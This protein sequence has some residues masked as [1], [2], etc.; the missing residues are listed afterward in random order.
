MPQGLRTVLYI[1][2]KEIAGQLPKAGALL[3]GGS[4]G[5]YV[6]QSPTVNT[7]SWVKLSGGLPA[8]PVT[9]LAYDAQDDLLIVATLG[10]GAWEFSNLRESIFGIPQ[11]VTIV[12]N[13]GTAIYQ[14]AVIPNVTLTA[15]PKELDVT[16][17]K[18]SSLDPTTLPL[19]LNPNSGILVVYAGDDGTFYDTSSGANA[20]DTL[21][22]S[23]TDD[24]VLTPGYV[25]FSQSNPDEVIFRFANDLRR[26]I[27]S[28]PCGP[29]IVC[30]RRPESRRSVAES[31]GHR[32]CRQP[33]N[34]RGT[35][36]GIELHLEPA[37]PGG[38]G[39][40]AADR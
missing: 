13:D 30:R 26:Q 23:D 27:R 7:A 5:V 34:R 21:N 15:T 2:G 16:F 8:A 19:P 22:T 38:C 20:T 12:S 1:S 28:H 36:P 33:A 6:T 11:V 39:G 40:P 10:R 18:N 32:F 35:E 3:V 25:G 14:G 17:N 4:Q 31:G 29:G 9:S 24:Q 37:A